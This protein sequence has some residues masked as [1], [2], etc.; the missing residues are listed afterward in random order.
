MQSSQNV[1]DINELLIKAL[2][3]DPAMLL[4]ARRSLYMRDFESF[5]IRAWKEIEPGTELKINWHL[6]YM[7]E[8]VLSMFP[9]EIKHLYP[10]ADWDN[11][12][13]RQLPDGTKVNKTYRMAIN[14]PP[15]T[16]KTVLLSIILPAWLLLHNN[17]LKIATVS[18]AADLSIDINNK[19][20]TLIN[21]DWYQEHFG[22]IVRADKGENRQDS[23]VLESKGELYATSVGGVFTGKGANIIILD[24]PQKPGEMGTKGGRDKAVEFFEKTLPTRFND[25][26]TG[27]LLLIQQ[28]LH[29]NDLTGYIE[30][31][32]G[33][34]YR[35][36]IVPA[37][38]RDGGQEYT[39]PL[40][41]KKVVTQEGELMWEER[42]PM[43]Y[44]DGLK[45]QMG[46]YNYAAQLQQRPTSEGGAH[47]ER[48]WF[49]KVA[50]TLAPHQLMKQFKDKD[51]E[52]YGRLRI[53]HSWDMNYTSDRKQEQ[54]Y[55]GLAVIA[56]DDETETSYLLEVRQIK[57]IFS[58]TILAVANKYEQYL[59]LYGEDRKKPTILIENKAN[60]GPIIEILKNKIAGVIPFDPGTQNKV[61]RLQSMT[62]I[63]A[64]GNVRIPDTAIASN[65]DWSL[66]AFM[67]QLLEFP[68]VDH[69]DMVDAFTQAL[70][71][72]HTDKTKRRN[73]FEIFF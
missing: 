2:A 29:K 73:K 8:E 5:M 64:S 20:R 15:R 50:Y 38:F 42:L 55:I 26:A 21:S 51:P 4:E 48:E 65:L 43:D 59:N 45:K 62:G 72:A 37:E 70:I 57:A 54:D 7:V 63:M 6:Q 33:D 67:N 66:T 35:Y 40:T 28:R 47:V 68:I 49:E 44:L 12:W 27:V 32:L 60:G 58:Q 22:D 10:D 18:Y 19:R 69:D 14:V 39:F 30:E 1:S 56:H 11:L 16:M 34:S 53:I 61:A 23:I 52:M 9:K 13:K 25:P 71:Y 46:V 24:D 31:K 36:V 17:T 41:G 3:S